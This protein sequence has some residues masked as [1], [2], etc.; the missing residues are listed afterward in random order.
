MLGDAE[1]RCLLDRIGRVLAGIGEAD[2]SRLRILCL[3]QIAGEVSG[4]QGTSDRPNTRP[5]CALT[6]AAVSR[7]SA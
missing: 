4:V 2:D 1:L 7:S 6:T 3:Q 5:P